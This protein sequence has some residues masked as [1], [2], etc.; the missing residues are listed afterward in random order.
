MIGKYLN[1]YVPETDGVPPG[2]DEWYVGGN[3]HRELRLHAQ[4]ERPAS[5]P[6]ATQPED[7][8]NDVLT[9]KAVQVIRR[10]GRGRRSRSSST[11]LPYTPHSPSVAAPRHEG[12]FA[13]APLPR[14]A[15]LR[16]GRR[17]RQARASSASC[18]R[19]TRSTIAWLEDEYRRRLASLQAVDDMVERIVGALRGERA[20][21]TTPTSST[22]RTT[23]FTWASTGCSPARTTA[24]EEDIR[25]P[26]IVRGP[27]VP[28]GRADRRHGRSTSTSRPTFAEIAGRRAARRSS[29]AARSCR[30]SQDPE[31]PW[32]ES[33]LIERRQLEEQY[34]ELA[35]QPAWRP[36][37]STAR[38]SSTRIRTA[39]WTYIEYGTGERELYDLARDPAPARQRGRDR[40]SGARRRARGAPCRAAHL[41]RRRMPP[42]GGSAP[43]RRRRAAAR[44]P[45]AVGHARSSRA[46]PTDRPAPG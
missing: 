3:A 31:Q 13:D 16:R 37:R 45:A 6:T 40:R 42:A 7:Y 46:R 39:D 41:R 38:R 35:E 9:G 34:V 28:A 22:A 1:R 29:T 33:F 4:R 11:S 36:T 44:R 30:C 19:S 23:A 27:G 8:L 24:Y 25:V 26:M 14:H 32:R 43:D 20:S 12:M 21:S 5:S 10:R 17:Q 18:R 15:G 2:W